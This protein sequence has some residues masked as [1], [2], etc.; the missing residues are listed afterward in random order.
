MS[1]KWNESPKPCRCKDCAGFC[2]IDACIYKNHPVTEPEKW[3]Y[4]D[5]Y[6]EIEKRR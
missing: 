4:C 6:K 1:R 5:E 3:R 2:P